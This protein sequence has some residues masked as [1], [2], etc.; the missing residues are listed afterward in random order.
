MF[1]FKHISDDLSSALS[2]PGGVDKW[3]TWFGGFMNKVKAAH[4]E[5]YTDVLCDIYKMIFGEHFNEDTAKMAVEGF[6]NTSGTK[7]ELINMKDA[8]SLA[9][10]HGVV[11]DKFN[12]YDYY[13]VINM[14]YSDNY[15][16]F[17]D[18][19]STYAMMAK[20]WLTDPDVPEGKAWRYWKY[21][22][23]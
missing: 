19:M 23:K 17:K 12:I 7:G 2:V 1:E 5:V 3:I 18:N 9:K 11:F 20:A 16:L 22:T 6:E 15:N 8:E 10:Q 21:V 4:P 13:F 14:M